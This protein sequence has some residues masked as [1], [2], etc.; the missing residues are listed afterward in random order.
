MS[1]FGENDLKLVAV[2]QASET[3]DL[4]ASADYPVLVREHVD[5]SRDRKPPA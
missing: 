1:P 5:L 4:V 2:V 3:E